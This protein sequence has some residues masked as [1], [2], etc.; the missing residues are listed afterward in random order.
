VNHFKAKI[1]DRLPLERSVRVRTKED[2][3]SS[4][5]P[6]SHYRDVPA[7][8]LLADPG[9]GKSDTF[10]TL[11]QIEGGYC[12][13]A[14]D[15]VE[16]TLPDGWQAPLFIDGLDEFTAGNTTGTTAL[17]QIRSK[18]QQLG[19]PRFRISCREADWRGNAD[20]EALQRLVG[21]GNFAELHLAP[22]SQ[23][24]TLALIGHWQPCSESKAKEFMREAELHDLEGLL[25]NPQTLSLLV[26]V[27]G[28][29]GNQWPDSKTKTY[30]MA[31]AQMVREHN[32][33]HLA[34]TSH[35]TL[36]DD[37]V[38]LA[39]GYLS[40]VMLL[41]GSGGIALQGQ[42]EPRAGVMALPELLSADS[43]PDLLACR[44]ALRTRLFRGDGH[45]DFWP[46]HRTIA[47]YL[48][49]KYLTQ[50][51]QGG[52]PASRVLALMQGEDA[53]IVPELR[54]L[55][56]WLASTESRQLR[57]EL[58]EE[59]PLG[60]VLNGDVRNF[61][62]TEKL[63]VLR[64]LRDEATRYT[65][66][67]SQNWASRP[68][69]ALA[70]ADMEGD[71]QALLQS[72]DRSPPHF[73]LLD[74]VLDALAHGQHMPTLAPA[75]EQVVRDKTYWPKLRTS[76]LGILVTDA[77]K[78]NNWSALM[79]LLADVHSNVVEDL[80]D[81]LLGALLQALYPSRISPLELWKHF[82]KPKVEHFLGAYRQFWY[83]LVNENVAQKDV[84]ALLDALLS[85]GY[86]LSNQRDNLGSSS[87]V[88]ELLVRGVI[89][90]GI[91]IQAQ[92]LYGWLSLG[93]GP[94]YYCSLGQK[95]KTV[96]GQWLSEHSVLYKTLFEHGLQLPT[97]ANDSGFSRLWRVRKHLYGAQEPTDAELWYLSL[98]QACSDDGVRRQLVTDAF[99]LTHQKDGPDAAILQLEKW[100]SN[101]PIDAT[102]VDGFL[103]CP[104][105]PEE[106]EQE[107]I[108]FEIQRKERE[109][110][111]S[112]Q[113]I[114][115]F[116]KTLP[117]FV[118]GPAHLGALVEVAQAYLDDHRKINGE[119]P[120]DRL[121]EL[122]NHDGAWVRTA[123][124]GLRQCLFH[125]DLPSAADIVDFIVEGR[126]YNLAEPCMAA[127]EL[128]YSDNPA[129]AL[130]LTTSSL[131]TVTAFCLT[132][133]FHETPD[134][135]KQM[136]VQHPAVVA[137]VMQ[138]LISQQIA[139]KKEHV[140]GLYTL[141]NGKGYAEVAKQ[142]VPQ[143]MA[144]FPVKASE[145]QLKNIRLLIVAMLTHL[146]RESQ[147]SLIAG[148]LSVKGMDV[149]QQAYWLTAGVL[150]APELYQDRILQF[151]KKSQMRVSHVF[152]LVHECGNRDGLQV[153]L[154]I[155]IQVFLIEQLGPRSNP[156]W[157]KERGLVTLEM[158]MSE[159]VAGLI[160]SLAGKPDDAAL[161]AL[162][163]LRQN[164]ALKHWNDSL[165]RAL[166]DQRITRRKA[167][168]KPTPVQQV[169]ATLANLKPANA[170]DLW[171]LT[172][173]HLTQ[174]IRQIRDSDTDDY[175]QYWD[176]DSPKSEERCRNALLSA[177]KLRLASLDISAQPERHHADKKRADIEVASGLIHI[178]L[179][180]KGEWHKD[181][182]K[183]IGNQLIAQYCREPASDGY[184]IYLVFW[185]TGDLKASD[186]GIR[187]KTPQ[188]LQQRLTATVPEALK[189]KIAVL[190]VDCSKPQAPPTA[191]EMGR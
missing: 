53:G 132:N 102:W 95:H 72:T 167:L 18:L 190:V 103:R 67:R 33:E 71:F 159:F 15:F 118:D 42:R 44:A 154:P 109:A 91:Q 119:T 85:T 16:L 150:L 99:R 22:L 24:Q 101:W 86:Q 124:Q 129:T 54:G 31:C 112:R 114:N 104:Y 134:W 11:S 156:S 26:K 92:R 81:E 59:D 108:D 78:D 141:A 110:E 143:L 165:S 122:L 14:R 52:L 149:G 153:V 164:Q 166:Y 49:A 73:S 136:L 146:D 35:N 161:Q 157:S 98:A 130:E 131:E 106:I 115:F 46:V 87:I 88:G 30:E 145:K 19:T 142:I 76:A 140:D 65:Y 128:R 148:K 180:A 111:E 139:A 13:T 155:A 61:S 27:I 10:E 183:A 66:F 152:A 116:H 93:L 20:S 126:R 127:M 82:R 177:L 70:T 17:G 21:N 133:N 63:G 178:P 158:N 172:V 96:L 113:Q 77:N 37:Q 39:A 174:L 170:A 181:V 43:A 179:E 58:I 79:Q 191:N 120:G 121:L 29:A 6:L 23:A 9:A 40:A 188:D 138:R 47:E 2:S 107:H 184:G 163:A 25:N 62:R 12:I 187:P 100:C 182:W 64:A 175:D 32:G 84:S 176:G 80:E 68:F 55:H 89:Q 50:C 185:F 57:R 186:G 83:E 144:N 162:T 160:A 105:P 147:C 5:E 94:Q 7:W 36:P 4:P 75:L 173:D 41:S 125:A 38:L 60:V 8:V 48:G 51:I 135:F 151:A 90:H 3:L 97:A 1:S 189:H 171:A 45:S 34:K 169:C 137:S 123:L 69:G 28:V 74:C 168:F 117:S 56:A